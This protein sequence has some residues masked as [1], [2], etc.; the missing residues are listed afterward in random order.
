MSSF[1]WTNTRLT[2]I[3]LL[4]VFSDEESM[5]L[6]SG[7]TPNTGLGESETNLEGQEDETNLSEL[8]ACNA[9]PFPPNSP[10]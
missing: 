5:Q 10:I 6:P 8:A 9:A 1:P 4:Q 2:N 7:P 3:S